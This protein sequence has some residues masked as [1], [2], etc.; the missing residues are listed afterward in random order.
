MKYRINPVKVLFMKKKVMFLIFVAGVLLASCGNDA[1]QIDPQSLPK[2]AKLTVTLQGTNPVSRS[3]GATV[4]ATENAIQR[5]A[6]GV[7]FSNNSTNVIKEFTAAE[8]TAAGG[9]ANL[10][11]A[12]ASTAQTVVVVANAPAGTF[13]G[14]TNL[15]GF[16]GKTLALAETLKDASGTAQSYQ[17]SVNLPMSGSVSSTITEGATTATATVPIY[18]LVSRVSLSS[19]KTQFDATGLYPNAKFKITDVF[20]YSGNSLSSV[21]PGTANPATISTPLSGINDSGT[22]VTSWL[23][24]SIAGTSTGGTTATEI[25]PASTVYWFYTFGNA[26]ANQT[27]LVIKG[28]WDENGDGDILDSGEGVVYYPVI[29]NKLQPGT[30][31]NDGTDD[32]ESSDNTAHKG[33][34]VILRNSTYAVSVVIKGKG[35]SSPGTDVIPAYLSVTINVQGWSL[36][37][38]QTIT[39][40]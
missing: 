9:T 10:Y 28:E 36:N 35:S 37:L 40:E 22:T 31:I 38:S 26:T 17:T 13:A 15:S 25:L 30:V 3:T 11:C 34:G 21:N 23:T 39:F 20:L 7:F 33:D 19:V 2:D 24:H 27:K 32:L 14:T 16:V 6:V 4:P 12:G 18:R 1:N 5:V 8:L 29:I